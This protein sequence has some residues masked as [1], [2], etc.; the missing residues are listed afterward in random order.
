MNNLGLYGF[1]SVEIFEN[2]NEQTQAKEPQFSFRFPNK[3]VDEK[4]EKSYNY[5]EP[6]I[7]E[8]IK[9]LNPSLYMF[10]YFKPSYFNIKKINCS[11]N[12]NSLSIINATMGQY[13]IQLKKKKM[14]Y[15]TPSGNYLN[16]C[17]SIY[18]ARVVIFTYFIA[19]MLISFC[20]IFLTLS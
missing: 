7:Y 4:S 15:I 10:K 20:Y 5:E 18:Y 8:N 1:S 11:Y 3:K 16:F 17:I 14:D 2:V 13:D 19:N 9:L 12:K 6:Q